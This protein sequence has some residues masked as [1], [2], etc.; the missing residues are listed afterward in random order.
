M[1]KTTCTS[2]RPTLLGVASTSLAGAGRGGRAQ[3]HVRLLHAMNQPSPPFPDWLSGRPT[4]LGVTSTSLA[5]AGRRG[6]EINVTA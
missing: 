4:L 3:Q 2:G 6:S 5:D 1:H